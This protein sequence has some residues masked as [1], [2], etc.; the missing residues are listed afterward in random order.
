MCKSGI[1]IH[2]KDFRDIFPLVF[3]GEGFAVEAFSFTHFTL[4]PDIGEQSHV[5]FFRPVPATRFTSAA[6]DVETKPSGFIAAQ[7]R[8]GQPRIECANTV[9]DFCVGRGVGT[10]CASDR[11]HVDVDNFVNDIGDRNAFPINDAPNIVVIPRYSLCFH[12]ITGECAVEN[13]VD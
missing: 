8:V 11:C 10:R 9:E 3:N 7:F 13:I 5:N 6:G 12:E 1:N 2:F 4:H